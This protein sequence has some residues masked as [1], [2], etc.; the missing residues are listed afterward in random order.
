MSSAK[1]HDL[2]VLLAGPMIR[3]TS[4]SEFTL[5]LVTSTPLK[6]SLRLKLWTQTAQLSSELIYDSPCINTSSVQVGTHCWIHLIAQH[7]A[8]LPT[9]TPVF[10]NLVCTHESDQAGDNSPIACGANSLFNDAKITFGREQYPSFFAPQKL[11][12]L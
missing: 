3:H 4:P 10:Y 8:A 5:W 9:Q 7:D 2:P 1:Q 6:N 12:N 11:T